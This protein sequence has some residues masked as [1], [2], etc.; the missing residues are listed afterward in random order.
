[1]NHKKFNQILWSVVGGVVLCVAVVILVA[2]VRVLMLDSYGERARIPAAQEAGNGDEGPGEAVV[3]CLPTTVRGAA[4]RWIGVS[5]VDRSL[6]L[7]R[8]VI[9]SGSSGEVRFSANCRLLD[10]RGRSPGRIQNAL[11]WDPASG[12]QHLLFPSRVLLERFEAPGEECDEAVELEPDRARELPVVPCDRLYWEV[13][14]EDTNG[15]GAIDS[16]DA[17]VPYISTLDGSDLRR[18][19]P[20]GTHLV[21]I[22]W[23]P[24]LGYFLQ[25]A[26]DADG[27]GHF[28]PRDPVELLR[29]DPA[30]DQVPHR[31]LSEEALAAT[32][33]LLK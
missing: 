11:A 6:P 25:A 30:E 15:D 13:R 29:F 23:D 12:E 22:A 27:D 20:P 19:T 16:D 8:N 2:I 9:G 17:L 14:E 26:T 31:V 28:G 32:D 10:G 7:S 4:I 5:I 24:D 1:M 3:L 33:A 21:S 18:M